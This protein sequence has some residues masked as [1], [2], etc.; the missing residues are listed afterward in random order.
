MQK[1]LIGVWAAATVALGVACAVQWKQLRASKE[2]AWQVEEALRAASQARE[3][4]SVRAK[5]L[6]QKSQRLEQQ[7][8][9]FVKLATTL[10]ASEAHQ[11]SNAIAMAEQL[12]AVRQNATDGQKSS[13]PSAGKG[14]PFGKGMGEMLSK[15][16]KDPDMREMMRGQ[17]KA[18]INMMYSGLFKELNLSA[19][20][21]EK[22]TA[23][24]TESQIKQMEN[25]QAL[26]G[27]DTSSSSEDSAKSFEEAKKQTEDEIRALLGEERFAH[28]QDYQKNL[29]ERMQLNQLKN[30]LEA[31]NLP[32]QEQQT[33]QLLQ[34]MSEE[35]SRIPP[36]IPT[37]NSPVPKRELFTSENL[38]RQLQWM[39]DYN[40]RVLERA[41]QFLSPEQLQHY[42]RFLDQQA[43]MQ[44]FSLNMARQMFGEEKAGAAGG[45]VIP[46]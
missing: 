46:K 42:R 25:A 31:Q 22:L 17:Q 10:R 28:Y 16:M 35:K 26:L 43:S 11:A 38:D 45:N 27:Q 23:I 7:V 29:S 34:A 41:G 12:Q 13:E 8:E 21:K 33:A 40:R 18:A 3:E 20:D 15:M 37:D 36:V 2:H 19:E 32:L 1:A 30:Q 14:A 5:E 9:E 24:L 44:K 6:E 4:Q 39:D